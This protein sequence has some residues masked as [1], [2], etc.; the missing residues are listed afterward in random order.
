MQ[1]GGHLV[2]SQDRIKIAT[3]LRDSLLNQWGG[4]LEM[5]EDNQF[6]LYNSDS[7]RYADCLELADAVKAAVSE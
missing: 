1:C 4:A 7:N 5:D 3:S 2:E 6:L